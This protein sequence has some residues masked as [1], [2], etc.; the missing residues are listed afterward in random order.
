MQSHARGLQIQGGDPWPTATGQRTQLLPPH[1]PVAQPAMQKAGVIS[2]DI[3]GAKP[4]LC[5][6]IQQA[7]N[8]IAHLQL[9]PDL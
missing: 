1:N 8:G 5:S 4:Y 7:Q 2:S 3:L 9:L 6:M